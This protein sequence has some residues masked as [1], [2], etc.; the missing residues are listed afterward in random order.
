MVAGAAGDQPAGGPVGLVAQLRDRGCTR[1]LVVGIDQ[2]GHR[3]RPRH[4]RRRHA[5]QPATSRIVAATCFHS[6][7][8]LAPSVRVPATQSETDCSRVK[9]RSPHGCAH[10]L[11]RFDQR[12]ANLLIGTLRTVSDASLLRSVA[13]LFTG[14]THV[15]ALLPHRGSR[16]ARRRARDVARRIHASTKDLPLLSACTATSTSA[17]LADDAPFGDPA[18]LLVV[19][20][21]YV[22]RMLVS[23]GV[24]PPTASASRAATAWT[25]GTRGRSGGVLRRAGTCSAAPRRGYWLEHEFAEVFGVTVHPRAETADELYDQLCRSGSPSRSSGRGRCS[26]GSG[27]RCWPPPTPPLDDLAHHATLRGGRLGRPGRPDLPA[28]R[29]SSTS[30]GPAGRRRRPL[31]RAHADIDTDDVRRLLHALRR[32]P[33][34][35]RRG[36]RAGH[37]PRAPRRGH[38]AAGG[39]PR[40]AGSTPTPVEGG[41]DAGDAARSPATCCYQMAA[42]SAEDGLVMQLHPGVLRDHDAAMP[43]RRTARTRA[44]TSRWPTS[45]PAVAAAAA[46]VVRPRPPVPAGGVHRRRDRVLARAGAAGRRLPGRAAR[47]AVVV[48][49]QPGRHAPVPRGRHRD[50][51]LLQHLRLRRRHPGVPAPSRPG[52]TW[53]AG[54]TPATWPG[55]SS[56]TGSTRTTRSGREGAGVQPGEG[57][58]PR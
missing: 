35:V 56:S 33:A 30:T 10:L 41:V 3:E 4:R 44:T 40:P 49:G 17:L 48:P 27:S 38:H 15:E 39:R 47:R 11:R 45:S 13:V 29:R 22:H 43:S 58:L 32:T 42:M 6:V 55:S 20:D 25:T 1:A 52:T 18:E 8:W 36:G 21:H 19:P 16:P 53:P 28:R 26:T 46:G 54:S 24:V 7:C 34:G 51:G 12:Q 37:R 31:R 5:G 50:G 23:Q 14:R 9:P 2:L 57:H